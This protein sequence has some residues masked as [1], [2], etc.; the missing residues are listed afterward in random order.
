MRVR[1]TYINIRTTP[2]EKFRFEQNAK[3]CGLSL[4]EYLRKL[5]NGYAPKPLPPV[6]F[7]ELIRLLTEIYDDFC[8]TS[9]T[10]YARFIVGVLSDMLEAVTPQ[11]RSDNDGPLEHPLRTQPFWHQ[12]RIIRRRQKAG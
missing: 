8:A 2:Q 7:A 6:E 9:E 11:K 1:E 12:F 5:A 4:S 3:R 10:E